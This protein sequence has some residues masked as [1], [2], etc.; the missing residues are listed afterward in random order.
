MSR[1]VHW[2]IPRVIPIYIGPFLNPCRSQ[3]LL[4]P[5]RGFISLRT[6]A[7]GRSFREARRLNLSPISLWVLGVLW[8]NRSFIFPASDDTGSRNG[9]NSPV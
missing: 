1:A 5:S 8:L 7:R 9:S 2:R 6:P 4:F 3:D